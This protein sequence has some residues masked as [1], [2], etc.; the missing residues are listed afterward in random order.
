M[1]A[2]GQ[3][4]PA[5]AGSSPQNPGPCNCSGGIIQKES[6]FNS[7]NDLRIFLNTLIKTLN[8]TSINGSLGLRLPSGRFNSS[9]YNHY[10]GKSEILPYM[11]QAGSG[12]FDLLPVFTIVRTKSLGVLGTQLSGEIRT[13]TNSRGYSLGNRADI[14]AWGAYYFFNGCSATARVTMSH[15]GKILG[16]DK[17]ASDLALYDPMYNTANTG[18]T[19]GTLHFGVNVAPQLFNRFKSTCGIEFGF[20]L[21]QRLNGI[22]PALTSLANVHF[23]FQ[24]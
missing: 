10:T 18:G 22:Q 21:F 24:I 6:H 16:S 11:L 14:S 15:W 4:I 7:L 20:P 17:A 1:M 12:T 5:G 13:G 9:G 2:N 8:Y 23:I 3:L 19:S